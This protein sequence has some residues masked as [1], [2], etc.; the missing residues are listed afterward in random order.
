MQTATNASASEQVTD[1]ALKVRMR[2]GDHAKFSRLVFDWP[3]KGVAHSSRREGDELVITFD[4]AAS[5]DFGGLNNDP[6]NFVKRIS[7]REQDGKTIVTATLA[8]GSVAST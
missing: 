5:I 3:V 6:L 1:G 4:K 8:S 2:S 7:G